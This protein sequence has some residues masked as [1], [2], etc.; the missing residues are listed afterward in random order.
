[1]KSGLRRERDFEQETNHE[2]NKRIRDEQQRRLRKELRSLDLITKQQ[3][4][5]HA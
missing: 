1:M 4:D 2:K 3:P 5:H